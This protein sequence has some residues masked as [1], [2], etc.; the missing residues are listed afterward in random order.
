MIDSITK[1]AWCVVAVSVAI[2]MAKGA[3]DTVNKKKGN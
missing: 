3:Y 1:A 2:I